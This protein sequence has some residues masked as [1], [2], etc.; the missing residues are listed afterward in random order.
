[1]ADQKTAT[2]VYEKGRLYTL[3]IGDIQPDPNQPAST[4][5]RRASLTAGNENFLPPANR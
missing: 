2:A 4:S 3:P 1:M 5:T